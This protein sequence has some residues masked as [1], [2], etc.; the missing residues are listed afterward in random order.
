MPM[1]QGCDSP[2][3]QETSV[4]FLG[5]E[6]P[7]EK[8]KAQFSSVA[9]SCLNLCDPKDCSTPGLPVHHQHLEFTQT[10]LH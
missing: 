7:L 3:M 2:E 1:S 8:G 4:Q 10:Q 9:Q 5:W 6:D